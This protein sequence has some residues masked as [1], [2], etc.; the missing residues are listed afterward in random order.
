MF[1][2][3]KSNLWLD[4]AIFLAFMITALT[5]LV[6]W[7]ILPEGPGSSSSIFWGLSKG[8]W[9]DIHD[10]AGVAMLLGAALHILLHLKW[11]SCVSKRYFGKLAKQARINFTLNSLLLLAFVLVNISGLVAWLALGQGGYRGGRNPGYN[12]TPIGMTRHQW[13][14]LHLWSGMAIVAILLIHVALHWK[15][16]VCTARRYA[17]NFG[18]RFRLM[19]PSR[20]SLS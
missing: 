2:K 10:W 7:L 4:G 15:W 6:L 16:I 8:V 9:T 18:D 14:D 3:A 11:I 13:N 12:A 20:A 5:G 19:N 1:G 17:N